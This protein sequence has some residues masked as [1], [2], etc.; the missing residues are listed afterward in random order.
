MTEKKVSRPRRRPLHIFPL[1]GPAHNTS[2]PDCWCLPEIEHHSCGD[3]IVH[4]QFSAGVQA[5]RRAQ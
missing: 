2:G 5:P 1:S 3:L 4:R